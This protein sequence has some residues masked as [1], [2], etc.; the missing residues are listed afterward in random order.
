MDYFASHEKEL[1]EIPGRTHVVFVYAIIALV[2]LFCSGSWERLK[3]EDG[4]DLLLTLKVKSDQPVTSV[5]D[6]ISQACSRTERLQGRCSPDRPQDCFCTAARLQ[7]RHQASS[8]DYGEAS[9][10]GV[11]A[12]GQ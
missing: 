2:F 9:I 12:R 5:M 11:Q 1:R 10:V 8:A 4:A 6:A 3:A 7:R